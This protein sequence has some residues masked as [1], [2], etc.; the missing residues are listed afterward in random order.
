MNNSGGL[1]SFVYDRLREDI[2]SGAYSAGEAI[3]ELG[4]S[5]ELAVSRTPVREALRQLELAG[6]VEITPNKGAVV[7]GITEDDIRDVYEIR[8]KIERGAA[9][10][11]A[12]NA[13]D[14]DIAKLTDIVELSE[15]Y[16]SRGK[17]EQL[18][19]IDGSFHTQVYKM[20]GSKIFDHVLGELHSYVSRWRENSLRTHSRAEASVHEHRQ[21]LEAIKSHD[22]ALAGDLATLHVKNAA[23]NMLK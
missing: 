22:A 9:E 5:R 2:L 19:G 1:T 11:A 23:E 16:A 17:I 6:L 12:K 10:R 20:S 15:F 14:E 7:I 3:T 4:V 21:I 8:A 18:R 13:T